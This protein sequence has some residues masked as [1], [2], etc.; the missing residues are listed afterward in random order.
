MSKETT[1]PQHVFESFTSNVFIDIVRVIC[2]AGI[3][4]FLYHYKINPVGSVL[5][6][7][8]FFL[9]LIFSAKTKIRIYADLVVF[10]I[11]RI[12]PFMSNKTR[13]N[14][15]DLKGL[16]FYKRTTHPI[17]FILSWLYSIKNVEFHF[18]L[19]DGTYNIRCL[20][21]NNTKALILKQIIEEKISQ[22]N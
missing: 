22:S 10:E 8:L 5:V 6:S 20:S 18:N 16:T 11:N 17:L 2:I 13:F 7:F 19:K 4:L 15:K 3:V 21:M 1:N 9:F 14:Y 12:L